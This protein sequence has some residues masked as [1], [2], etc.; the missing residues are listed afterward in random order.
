MSNFDDTEVLLKLDE[1]IENQLPQALEKAM[2]DAVLFL[3]AESKKNCP[4]IKGTLRQSITNEVEVK[5]DGVYGYVGSNL[6]YA[7]YVHQGTGIFA[8][9]GNGRSEV[10][11]RYQDAQGNWYSTYGM[12]STPFIQDAI[13]ANRDAVTQFFKGALEDGK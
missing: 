7:P 2:K 10:P 13:N 8:I 3:E 12:L 11:W 9:D 5:P 4:A 1:L 6:D